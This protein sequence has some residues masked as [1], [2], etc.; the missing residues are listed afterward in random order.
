MQNTE[1]DDEDAV[2]QMDLEDDDDFST[3]SRVKFMGGANGGSKHKTRNLSRDIMGV[4]VIAMAFFIPLLF[5]GGYYAGTF[6]WSKAMAIDIAESGHTL[7]TA[8][9]R[10]ILTLR[11]LWMT[12]NAIAEDEHAVALSRIDLALQLSHELQWINELLLYGGP[13]VHPARELE[14]RIGIMISDGCVQP[15]KLMEC[16]DVFSGVLSTGLHPGLAEFVRRSQSLLLGRQN[17][18][19]SGTDATL[20]ERVSDP[21]LHE[22]RVFVEDHMKP[23]LDEITAT[24]LEHVYED[25]VHFHRLLAAI[26]AIAA[27]VI[28]A[29][30]A[31]LQLPTLDA[32]DAGIKRSR[33][34]LLYLPPTAIEQVPALRTLIVNASV[35]SPMQVAELKRN[36][37]R[38]FA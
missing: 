33:A 19:Q 5:A 26:S 10:E 16:R 15:S 1:A 31:T 13:R 34:V 32:L 24:L 8:H 18:I 21:E 23:A 36:S 30:Y 35:L 6:V 17:A 11:L 22:L 38:S 7:I 4:V 9:Q 25:V 3:L 29:G 14:H 12:E 20:D 27:I 2:D 37:R 28:T